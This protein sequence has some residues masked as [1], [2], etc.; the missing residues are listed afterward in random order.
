[1]KRILAL[2]LVLVSV[3]T[4]GQSV[5]TV[6]YERK[7]NMHRRITDEQMRAMI[8]EWRT[9]KHLL[10]FSDSVSVYKTLP[11]NEAPDP[12]EGGGGG[13][14]V[15]IRMGAPGDGGLTYKNFSN[16]MSLIETDLGDKTYIIQDTI[17]Q[18]GWKLSE[19]TKTI[20]GVTCKKA[21]MKVA[22]PRGGGG[23]QIRSMN[24]GPATRTDTTRT[25]PPQDITVVAWY[26]ESLPTPVGPDNYGNLPGLVLEVDMNNGE[27]I[28][29]AIDLKKTVDAKELKE[30]KKGKRITR[31]DFA[32][33]Q[34]EMFRNMQMGGGGSFRIGG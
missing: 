27:T 16:G 12:F 24:G 9:S 32:S 13:G 10:M 33:K 25:A 26:A 2:S 23:F 14:R 19:E 6:T 20:L 30:P 8:P 15:T 29:S 28:Y 18:P 31:A 5:G 3:T 17:K 11:E 34:Q 1:M 4:F 22:A 21:T 7:M